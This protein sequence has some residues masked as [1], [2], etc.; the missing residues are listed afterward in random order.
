[1]NQNGPPGLPGKLGRVQQNRVARG[2]FVAPARAAT[3]GP[4]V[5][6][7]PRAQLGLGLSLSSLLCAVSQAAGL[8]AC[9]LLAAAGVGV[10]ICAPLY[11]LPPSIQ[12]HGPIQHTSHLSLS[13]VLSLPRHP[14]SLPPS[15]GMQA[16]ESLS[17]LSVSILEVVNNFVASSRNFDSVSIELLLDQYSST[18]SSSCCD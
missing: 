3:T 14:S 8:C 5:P 6:F 9:N 16:E 17:Y 7:H 4:S 18:I 1:M 13:A 15:I 2:C 10:Y 12:E 11:R